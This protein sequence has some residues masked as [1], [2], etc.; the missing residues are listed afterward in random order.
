[1]SLFDMIW[2]CCSYYCCQRLGETVVNHGSITHEFRIVCSRLSFLTGE[3]ELAIVVEVLLYVSK[4]VACTLGIDL[5]FVEHL[6][7][8]WHLGLVGRLLGYFGGSFRSR[9]RQV[10]D[11]RQHFDWEQDIESR[12]DIERRQQHADRQQDF[13]RQRDFDRRRS[14]K[15]HHAQVQPLES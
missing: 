1:M 6:V 7:Y 12:R 15:G 10:E 8:A 5:P 4:V 11:R 9:R 14:M 3:I 2:F 13:E